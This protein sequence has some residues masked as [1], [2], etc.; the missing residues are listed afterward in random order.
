M[1]IG[2]RITSDDSAEARFRRNTNLRILEDLLPAV[3]QRWRSGETVEKITIG[4]AQA[5]SQ[6]RDTVRYLVQGLVMLCQLPATLA[7]AREAL[8]LDEPRIAALGRRLKQVTD[9]DVLSLI[10]DDIA[11]II[12]PGLASQELILPAAF[13][14]RIANILDRHNIR[15]EKSRPA[16]PRGSARIDENNDYCFSFAVDR[17]QGAKLI[18]VIEEIKKE[19]GCELGEALALIVGKQTAGTQATL[20]LYLDVTGKVYLRGVGWLRPEELAGVELADLS[21]LNPA[22][23]TGNW[24]AAR[25]YRIPKKLRELVKAR[26]GGCRAPGCTASIDCCQID[27]VIPFSKGG[28]T[29]LDNL[30]AL[31]PHCHDQKTNGVFEVSMAPNG[32]DTWTL[33]DGTIERTLP[34]GPW[35]EIMMAEATAISPTQKIPTR[36]TYAGLKARKAKAAARAAG[37]RTKRRQNAGENPSSQ[38]AAA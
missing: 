20:N 38:R 5:L 18:A 11:A 25:K 30:H 15:V 8:V 6:K 12:T 3:A 21:M 9:S 31:C 35:A 1:N 17:V 7:A 32:I 10:D 13:S 4:L 37:K 14:Q 24:H 19:H 16:T 27:H 26:D 2:F 28:T 34:K 29:S 22:S 23:F 36:P 33:P